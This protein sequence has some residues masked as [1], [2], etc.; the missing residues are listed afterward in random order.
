M[1]KIHSHAAFEILKGIAFPWPVAQIVLQHHERMDG[2]GYPDGIA[3]DRLLLETR[4]I[5]VAGVIEAM[6]SHRPYRPALG[7]EQAF[8]EVGKGRGSRYDPEVVEACFKLFDGDAL[9]RL[10]K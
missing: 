7:I 9:L 1:I 5:A 8:D 3:G 10:L 2:S 6:A 4:I